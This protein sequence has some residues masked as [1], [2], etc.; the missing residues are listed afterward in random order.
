MSFSCL[1]FRTSSSRVCCDLSRI[2][3]PI[4]Y[5]L[6]S[7]LKIETTFKFIVTLFFLETSLWWLKLKVFYVHVVA[8]WSH[9]IKMLPFWSWCLYGES[10]PIS[11]P[12]SSCHIFQ[13]LHS[14]V[15]P[16]C[17]QQVKLRKHLACFCLLKANPIC[18]FGYQRF[19]IICE[20]IL[21]FWSF[22]ASSTPN[23]PFGLVLSASWN[24]Q[25]S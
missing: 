3:Y 8:R 25:K 14:A 18:S 19:Y 13:F 5:M 11:H 12:V 15:C 10:S 22:L 21:F 23:I 24:D 1:W 7:L 9:A 6:C 20:V 16:Q 4:L 2:L 17:K